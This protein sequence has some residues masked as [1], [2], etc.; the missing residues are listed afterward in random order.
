MKMKIRI[1]PDNP[2]SGIMTTFDDGKEDAFLKHLN[3]LL[4]I[5][6]WAFGLSAPI[7]VPSSKNDL[8]KTTSLIGNEEFIIKEARRGGK[9]Q[10]IFKA[11]PLDSQPYDFVEFA[12]KVA[13]HAL[14]GF[15]KALANAFGYQAITLQGYE[16]D[17]VWR[18]VKEAF[19]I[20]WN[21]K[22]ADDAAKEKKQQD[23]IYSDN[24]HWGM[25]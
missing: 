3:G 13:P 14:V 16:P 12:E 24:P 17:V 9:G 4:G 10:I 11:R 8:F 21:R 15:D 23:A 5:G 19:E 20:D 1:N 18:C 25:F 6:E 7:K 22:I 2:E